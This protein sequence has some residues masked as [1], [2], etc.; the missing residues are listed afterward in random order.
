MNALL[1]IRPR[2]AAAIFEGEKLFEFRRSIFRRQVNRVVVYVTQP[3]GLVLGEFEVRGIVEGSPASLWTRTRAAAGID[4]AS[5]FEYFDGREVGYA[6]QIGKVR[7]YRTPLC[8][9][10]TFGI[11]PPQSFAYLNQTPAA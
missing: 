11:R 8:I 1:S 10:A 5:F 6:I 4:R 2:Y 7:R 3:V 9:R